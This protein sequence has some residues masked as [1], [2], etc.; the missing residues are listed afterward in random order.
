VFADI[1]ES[2]MTDPETLLVSHNRLRRSG[3]ISNSASSLS[4]APVVKGKGNAFMPDAH[5]YVPTAPKLGIRQMVL[6]EEPK[7]NFA[8]SGGEDEGD[9]T[10][11]D[12]EVEE[13]E[14]D[15]M[16]IDA[17][18]GVSKKSSGRR[19]EGDSD[20]SDDEDDDD[21]EEDFRDVVT[22]TSNAAVLAGPL[23]VSSGVTV[24]GSA[25]NSAASARSISIRR[26]VF[27]TGSGLQVPSVL[28]IEMEEVERLAS[29]ETGPNEEQMIENGG[30]GVAMMALQVLG[31]SRRIK[32]GNHNSAPTVVVMAGNNKTGAYGLCAARHL[33]NHEVNVIV[34]SVGEEAEQSNVSILN[35]VSSG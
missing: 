21:D 18:V 32:P 8:T 27:V 29:A 26:P 5:A 15:S 22:P 3:D 19:G 31:G 35:D 6:E 17:M 2:D 23:V 1:R 9:E 14:T 10:G 4:S 34:V 13:S 24:S 30:R 16:F 25:S 33:A 12:A 7:E 11:N 20:D 28:P